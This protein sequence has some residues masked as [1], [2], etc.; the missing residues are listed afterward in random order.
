[1][2]N[3]EELIKLTITSPEDVIESIQ[4]ADEAFDARCAIELGVAEMTVG[5]SPRRTSPV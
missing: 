5:G 1:M 2:N 4:A 3:V